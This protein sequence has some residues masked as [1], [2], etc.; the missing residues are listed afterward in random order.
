MN[1]KLKNTKLPSTIAQ[2]CL[3]KYIIFTCLMVLVTMI[4]TTCV[5]TIP[6]LRNLYD[7]FYMALGF[8]VLGA[9][10]V[11]MLII[12]EKVREIFPLNEVLISLSVLLWSFAIPAVTKSMRFLVFA[13]WGI[14]VILDVVALIIG[15]K[16]VKQS[17]KVSIILLGIAGG[18]ILLDIILLI[19]LRV[20]QRELIAVILCGIFLAFAVLI[21]LYLTGQ[22]V[23]RCNNE[24]TKTLLPMWLSLITWA[25]SVY[26]FISIGVMFIEGKTMIR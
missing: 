10:P 8:L 3:R 12:I 11:S 1:K 24:T 17:A 15:Y 25:A 23:K 5:A 2:T 7:T 22:G 19:A 6:A 18:I 26:L 14:T 21:V 13:P 9:I 4:T 20:A 16:T